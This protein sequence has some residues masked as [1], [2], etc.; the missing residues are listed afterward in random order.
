MPAHPFHFIPVS[1]ATNR[2]YFARDCRSRPEED[3]FENK[4][5]NV[6][7]LST[8]SWDIRSPLIDALFSSEGYFH[9]DIF[10]SPALPKHAWST[11]YADPGIH[12]ITLVGTEWLC[13]CAAIFHTQIYLPDAKKA[14]GPY[15]RV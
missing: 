6:D 11:N 5:G 4:D 8:T 2:L 14:S 1:N 3:S 9:G 12:K 10:T 15:L 7:V 13:N